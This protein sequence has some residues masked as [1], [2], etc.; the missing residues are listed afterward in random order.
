MILVNVSCLTREILLKN[1]H[2]LKTNKKKRIF[3][4][5]LLF[6]YFL[7]KKLQNKIKYNKN[8]EKNVLKFVCTSNLQIILIVSIIYVLQQSKRNVTYNTWNITLYV[9]K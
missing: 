6:I 4:K 7:K 1:Y 5:S 3:I 9:F 8:K 2:K